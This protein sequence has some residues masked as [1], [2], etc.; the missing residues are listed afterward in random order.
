MSDKTEVMSFRQNNRIKLFLF[1]TT[2][3][4][5]QICILVPRSILPAPSL[6]LTKK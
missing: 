5:I 4:A 3:V 1:S 6:L 2:V